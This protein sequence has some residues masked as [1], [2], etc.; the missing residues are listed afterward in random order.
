MRFLR[1]CRSSP[2]G[3]ACESAGRVCGRLGVTA[4]MYLRCLVAFDPV[5]GDA[6]RTVRDGDRAALLE[7]EGLERAPHR[8][9]V[10]VG[11]AA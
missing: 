1:R 11:V 3:I 7:S 4:A 10:L 2:L 9:V 5:V 8:G 6:L